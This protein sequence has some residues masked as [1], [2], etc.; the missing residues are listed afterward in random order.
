VKGEA[1]RGRSHVKEMVSLHVQRA[2]FVIGE[3]ILAG[4]LYSILK[5]RMSRNNNLLV[6]LMNLRVVLLQLRTF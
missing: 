6:A 3:L 1:K 5:D 2:Q 4:G